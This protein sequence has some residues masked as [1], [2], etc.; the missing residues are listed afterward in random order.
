MVSKVTELQKSR[1]FNVLWKTFGK[2]LKGQVVTMEIISNQMWSRICKELELKCNKFSEGD[3]KLREIDGYL[4]TFRTNY[5][6][7]VKEFMLLSQYFNGKREFDRIK[8]KLVAIMEKVKNYKELFHAQE[9]ARAIL[10]LQKVFSL[11]G[12]FAKVKSIEQV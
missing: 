6:A 1:L 3:V 12:D 2:E 7:V 10:H 4:D 9:A 8:N 11:T 5:D